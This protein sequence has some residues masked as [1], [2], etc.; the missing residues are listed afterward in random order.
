MVITKTGAVHRIEGEEFRYHAESDTFGAWPWFVDLEAE[1]GEGKCACPDWERAVSVRRQR[2]ET[3]QMRRLCKHIKRAL[4]DW[5]HRKFREQHGANGDKLLE[6]M[7]PRAIV[8]WALRQI[9]KHVREQ[10]KLRKG[11]KEME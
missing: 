7:P 5:A 11:R 2:G 6:K 4:N 1:N 8:L 9:K 3:N 10:R